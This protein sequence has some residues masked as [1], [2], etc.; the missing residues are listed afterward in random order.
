VFYYTLNRL[1]K[2]LERYFTR[3]YDFYL[4]EG[5]LEEAKAIS[6]DAVQQLASQLNMQHGVEQAAVMILC[7]L[8][9]RVP[10]PQSAEAMDKLKAWAE[11]L[12]A[13]LDPTIVPT[14]GQQRYEQQMMEQAHSTATE[15]WVAFRAFN[16]DPVG[17]GNEWAR[18]QALQV[19]EQLEQFG[20]AAHR[21]WLL[22]NQPHRVPPTKAIARLRPEAEEFVFL[23]RSDPNQSVVESSTGNATPTTTQDSGN[24]DSGYESSLGSNP[25]EESFSG[26]TS[27]EKIFT[28]P[29]TTASGDELESLIRNELPK[30]LNKVV[31]EHE[32]LPQPPQRNGTEATA[33]G[34]E[35]LSKRPSSPSV[36][37]STRTRRSSIDSKQVGI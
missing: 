30:K 34:N 25:S 31:P 1:E 37:S 16:K 6:N 12:Y 15:L 27:K 9:N 32:A 33:H 21:L 24:L 10:L 19:Y 7:S 18:Q 26:T 3:Y 5:R 14:L 35:E 36:G 17:W 8:Y 11:Y 20:D 29:E 22:E 28:P 2:Y 4:E 23:P 13:H